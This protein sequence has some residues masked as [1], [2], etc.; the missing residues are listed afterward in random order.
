MSYMLSYPKSSTKI[1]FISLIC[2][3]TSIRQRNTS[4]REKKKQNLW[5]YFRYTPLERVCTRKGMFIGRR[6]SF[7]GYRRAP[8]P[9]IRFFFLLIIH[10]G[11]CVGGE[12]AGDDK[13]SSL[14]SSIWHFANS[15]AFFEGQVAFRRCMYIFFL[16]NIS[17]RKECLRLLWRK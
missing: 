3:H 6:K 15:P 8:Q 10:G 5:H 11:E 13:K 7:P 12:K 2:I 17:Y 16:G 1:T 9:D 4:L 14:C